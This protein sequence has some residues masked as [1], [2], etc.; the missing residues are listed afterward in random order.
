MKEYIIIKEK[1][2]NEAAEEAE[3]EGKLR[4]IRKTRTR[5][6]SIVTRRK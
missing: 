1:T 3:R 4:K 2:E 6:K 5:R